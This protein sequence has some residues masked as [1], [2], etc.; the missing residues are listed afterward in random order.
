MKTA[1]NC[2]LIL[3]VFTFASGM[4]YVT[5]EEYSHHVSANLERLMYHGTG[6]STRYETALS[7]SGLHMLQD[8]GL[9]LRK[10]PTRVLANYGL[11]LNPLP[12]EF[13]PEPRE[14][15][16]STVNTFTLWV[17]ETGAR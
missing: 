8:L 6:L 9:W 17:P 3:T 13:G 5:D 16:A 11:A 1:R 10:P 14:S 2:A 7:T 15:F 4:R 12:A